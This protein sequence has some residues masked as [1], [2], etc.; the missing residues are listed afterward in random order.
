MMTFSPG[1]VDGDE[2]N[3]GSLTHLFAVITDERS[4]TPPEP[5]ARDGV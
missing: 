4:W 1:G 3:R 2:E 5:V